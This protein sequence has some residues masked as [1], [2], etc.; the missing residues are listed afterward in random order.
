M[1][2]AS[3]IICFFCVYR[4]LQWLLTTRGRSALIDA[5]TDYLL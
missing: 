2:I 5:L 4:H 3:L 1:K